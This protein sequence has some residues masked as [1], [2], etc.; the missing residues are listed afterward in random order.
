[1]M[2]SMDVPP[3]LHFN[4]KTDDRTLDVLGIFVQ[5]NPCGLWIPNDINKINYGL[6]GSYGLIWTRYK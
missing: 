5:T 6:Y 2:V 3:K 1:M 4:R